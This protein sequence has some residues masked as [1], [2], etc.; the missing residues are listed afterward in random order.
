MT[1]EEMKSVEIYGWLLLFCLVIVMIHSFSPCSPLHAILDTVVVYVF[2]GKLLMKAFSLAQKFQGQM[3][4]IARPKVISPRTCTAVILLHGIVFLCSYI[5]ANS[6]TTFFVFS[7]QSRGQKSLTTLISPLCFLGWP[8]LEPSL[9]SLILLQM[10]ER[11]E[12]EPGEKCVDLRFPSP[13]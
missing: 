12:V 2:I 8:G 5:T 13:T 1:A 11:E 7:C 4:T 3:E 10:V 6:S 9:C